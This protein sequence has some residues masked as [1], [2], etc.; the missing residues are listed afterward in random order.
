ML[1]APKQ[2]KPGKSLNVVQALESDRKIKGHVF[3]ELADPNAKFEA[4]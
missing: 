3:E 2:Q 4:K 1:D